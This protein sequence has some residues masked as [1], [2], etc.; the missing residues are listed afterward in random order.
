MG[1]NNPFSLEKACQN[2]TVLKLSWNREKQEGTV[3]ANDTKH[4]QG[5]FG[6]KYQV[7]SGVAELAGVKG[8]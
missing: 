4:K 3:P 6:G 5:T 2:K 8:R 1:E 7:H